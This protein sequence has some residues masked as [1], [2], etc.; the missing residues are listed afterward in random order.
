MFRLQCIRCGYSRDYEIEELLWASCPRCG[1]VMGV[2][3][4]GQL[5]RVQREERGIWRYSRLLPRLANKISRGEG[6][7]PLTLI[8]GVLVKNERFNPTGTYTDRAASVIA[9]FLKEVGAREI[10]IEYVQDFARSIAYYVRSLGITVIARDPFNIDAEEALF[11]ALRGVRIS[12]GADAHAIRYA[13]PLT[14][15]GLKTII[16]ELYERRA[17][18]EGVVA[19]TITGALTLSLL[20]GIGDLKDAG[21]DANYEVIAAVPKGV[22]PPYLEGVK[23]IKVIEI[24]GDEL[25][26]AFERLVRKGFRVKPIVALSYYVAENLGKHVAIATMGY[27]PPR[28]PRHSE[29]KK[30]I[31]DILSRHGPLTAYEVWKRE[32]LYTLRA[33]YKAIRSMEERGEICSDVISRGGRKAKVYRPC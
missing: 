16:F 25:Y 31:I 1:G 23:G 12:G 14:L 30:L 26:G 24:P 8:N 29:V 17:R 28:G 5:F 13:N 21:I 27:R 4:E 20:K 22:R 11:L 7:T 32:P 33:V 15:E 19:P 9:S 10:Y 3:Y 6:L 18:V 2:A